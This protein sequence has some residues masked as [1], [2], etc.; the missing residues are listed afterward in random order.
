MHREADGGQIS[1]Q[2]QSL[3]QHGLLENPTAT[4]A[5]STSDGNDHN[6]SLAE[7]TL[8][9]I[10]GG[11]PREQRQGGTASGVASDSS[12][13]SYTEQRIRERVKEGK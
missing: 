4:S 7:R 6:P 11:V 2:N 1:W 10:A 3:R 12:T 9:R 5:A 13:T 8:D